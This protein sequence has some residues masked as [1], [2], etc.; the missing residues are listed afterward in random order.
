M[1]YA[2]LVVLICSCGG[3]E[4]PSRIPKKPN[5]ELIVGDFERH[6]PAGTTAYRFGSDGSFFAGKTKAEI[7]RT[8]HLSEGTYKV[9][10]DTLTFEAVR[11]EC[12]ADAKTGTYKVVISKIGI[13]FEKLEDSCEWRG[14]L[15]GQTLWRIK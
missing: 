15:T 10:G 5:D 12:S 2:I 8:P 3:S 14:R 6:P 4:P 1:R 7:E 9:T 13:H 11:G